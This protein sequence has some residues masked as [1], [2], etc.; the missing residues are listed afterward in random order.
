[1]PTCTVTGTAQAVRRGEDAEVA[2]RKIARGD[3][4]PDVL[5]QAELAAARASAI[6]VVQL[7]RFP[8]QTEL[9]G[10]NV[11]RDALGGRADAREFVVVNRARAVHRDVVDA[12]RARADR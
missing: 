4:P 5:A 6:H 12:R 11:A 1:M 2:M 10:L 8:P 9:A 7:A 3:S